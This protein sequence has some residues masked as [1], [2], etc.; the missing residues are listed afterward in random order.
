[1]PRINEAILPTMNV[2]VAEPSPTT[3][4][5]NTFLFT[6]MFADIAIMKPVIASIKAANTNDNGKAMVTEME[7]KYGIK[8]TKAPIM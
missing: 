6:S 3:I 5:S 4:S 8:G 7:R 2:I 1:M